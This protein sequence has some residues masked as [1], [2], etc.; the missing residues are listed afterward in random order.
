MW[1]AMKP[2]SAE[3]PAHV[4]HPGHVLGRDVDEEVGRRGLD[5]LAGGRQRDQGGGK[6]EGEDAGRGMAAVRPEG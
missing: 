6:R 5:L 4:R 3:H 1:R 2:P